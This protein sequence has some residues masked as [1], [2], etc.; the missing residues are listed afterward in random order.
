MYFRLRK[1]LRDCRL[2]VAAALAAVTLAAA[3]PAA[4]QPGVPTVA[5]G[6]EYV[7]PHLL[8]DVGGGRKINMV[9]MGSGKVTVLFDS[10]LSDWS[11]IWALVQPGVAKGAR[12]CSYDRAGMGY[13]DPSADPRSTISIVEDMHKLVHQGGLKTPLVLVGHSLGGFNVKLYAAL[14]PADVGGLVLVDPAEDRIGDRTRNL[15]RRR[16]GSAIAARAELLDQS[17]MTKA[18]A[19]Y[20]ACAAAAR[21]H[22]LDPSSGFY[23]SC[24]DPVR[25]PL[26]SVI[27][28]DR[29]R[30]QVERAYQE[31][32][33]SELSNSVYADARG[34]HAYAM[35]FHPGAF[36][37]KPLIVLTHSIYDRTDPIDAAGFAAWNEVHEQTA[38]LSRNGRNRLVPNTHHNIEVDDPQ[39]IVDAVSQVM[40]EMRARGAKHH[41]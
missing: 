22:T 9:C 25:A 41:K 2:L 31:T 12:A 21:V 27:A 39:A 24:T 26:G 15:L 11:S 8:V 29:A 10:G 23:K 3:Q 40:S 35:L 17:E 5:I 19:H 36:G 28:G 38:R 16:F 33:A 14:Y 34:D 4:T 1:L 6:A 20:G 7:G 13:S 30:L 18:I 37:D 32:Q